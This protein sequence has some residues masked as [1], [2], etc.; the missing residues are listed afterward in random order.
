M[1]FLVILSP[2]PN[3]RGQAGRA[4]HVQH[5]TEPTFRP[6]LHR[7]CWAMRFSLPGSKPKERSA[8]NPTRA[9]SYR[10]PW[11]ILVITMAW[12]QP[13]SLLVPKRLVEPV[14]AGDDK[15][16]ESDERHAEK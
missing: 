6:C 7:F 14:Y 1:R 3:V 16:V 9:E 12:E 4:E 11:L 10:H 13:P 8:P 5:A 2:Q 15:P